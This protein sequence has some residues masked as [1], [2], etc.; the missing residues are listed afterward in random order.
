MVNKKKMKSLKCEVVTKMRFRNKMW[1]KQMI[2]LNKVW[3]KQK[4][5]RLK[6]NV[7]I[8]RRFMNRM[9]IKQTI[10]LNKVMNKK[11]EC[12]RYM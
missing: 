5:K 10:I 6:Y 12:G 11:V 7:E 3:N 2:S 8:K 4:M 9:G 1:I